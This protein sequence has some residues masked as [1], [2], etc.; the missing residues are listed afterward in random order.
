MVRVPFHYQVDLFRYSPYYI[1]QQLR[2]AMLHLSLS[3]PY[4]HGFRAR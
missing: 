3:R 4:A 1:E 2:E